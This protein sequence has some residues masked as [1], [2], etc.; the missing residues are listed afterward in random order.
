MKKNLRFKIALSLFVFACLPLGVCAKDEWTQV[1]SKNFNL[2]GN[3]SEKDIRRV[4]D[5]LEQFR[6]TFR[7]LFS[8]VNFT[9]P[10]QTNV[11]VFKSKNAYKPFLP[12][13]ADGKADTEIAG[14]FQSGEDVN[15]ITISTEGDDAETFGTIFHEYV[16]FMV[17]THFGESEVPPWFNE[18]LAE[19]YQTF[20]IEEDQKVK[21]GLPQNEHLM[22]LQQT[23]LIPLD[24]LFKIDNYSLHQNGNHSRSIFYAQAWALIH[25]LMQGG[26]TE[27]LGKFLEAV[28]K[29]TPAEKAFQDSFQMSYAQMEKELKK[30]V[31]QNTYKYQ[32][33]SFKNKLTFDGEMKSSPMSEADTNAY[34]GDLLY[35]TNRADD[36]EPYLQKALALA[37]DSSLA[38]TAF[39]MVRMRQRKFAEAKVY[40]EKAVASDRQ[41]HLAFYNFAFLLSREGMNESGYVSGYPADK[42]IRMRDLLKK[43]I[44][45]KPDFTAGYDLLAF[46]G[47]VN[48]ENLDEAVGYLQQ[49]LKYQPGNE[50]YRFRIAEIYIRQDKIAEA[51]AIAERIAK[52]T[53]DPQLKPQAE[54]LSRQIRRMQE[55]T[56][57]QEKIRREYEDAQKQAAARGENPRLVRHTDQGVVKVSAEDADKTNQAAESRWINQSLRKP[58]PDEKRIVA[59]IE[60]IECTNGKINY[61]IKSGSEKFTLFSKDFEG[62]MMSSF[63][64]DAVSAEIGCGAKIA[65]LNMVLT[66]KPLSEPKSPIRGELTIIEFVPAFFQLMTA[67]DLEKELE[68]SSTENIPTITASGGREGIFRSIRRDL[69]KPRD[70]EKQTLGTL[71]KTECTNRGV[72]FHFK[73]RDQILKFS[74]STPQTLKIRAFTP[75]I[76]ALQF[77]C[78]MKPLEIPAVVTYREN[79]DSKNNLQGEIFSLEF[80]PK[81]FKLE[82]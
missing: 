81:D 44:A 35:H 45:S 37:S 17:N 3:A 51:L 68:P 28:M 25:Y 20:V 40:L 75:E 5:K 33:I 27:G 34:L 77:G 15:Y 52:N 18:G 67:D 1:R 72:V 57:E 14:Y 30:Y 11:V 19:Y 7:Q 73:V 66:Y 76:G 12:L 78:N 60:S 55:T 79:A 56:A 21:L 10:I 59:H 48:D 50:R 36:A 26:K 16:H 46:I 23:K 13:R 32:Q 54:D 82:N 47:L 80:V 22:L 61:Q 63:S 64:S 9:S 53:G 4:A 43:V 24:T 70:G 58:Q 38:N 71:E 8:G 6:E 42:T 41:N 31:A 29:N 2:V 65:N 62:L 74:T 39:G 49:A 69:Q